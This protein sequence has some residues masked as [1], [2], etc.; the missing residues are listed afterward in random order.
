ML[1]RIL[2]AK[3]ALLVALLFCGTSAYAVWQVDLESK[4]VDEGEDGD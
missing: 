2:A 3:I 4:A 1:R